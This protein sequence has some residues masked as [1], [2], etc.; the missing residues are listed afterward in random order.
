[1]DSDDYPL[2][3]SSPSSVRQLTPA[4]SDDESKIVS[5]EL[6]RTETIRNDTTFEVTELA[7]QMCK[8]A[9]SEDKERIMPSTISAYLQQAGMSSAKEKTF[10]EWLYLHD[11]SLK[12]AD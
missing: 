12:N 11:E 2:S 8:L 5:S 7:E 1:M 3:I 9:V 6:V 4:T 10:L